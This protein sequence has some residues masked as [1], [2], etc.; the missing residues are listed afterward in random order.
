MTDYYDK[1]S[2]PSE[3]DDDEEAHNDIITLC[4]LVEEYKARIDD[5]KQ[6]LE[7]NSAAFD[8]LNEVMYK[9]YCIV[10]VVAYECI[11]VGQPVAQGA[12]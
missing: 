9:S 3:A 7:D 12:P 6:Q 4:H 5:F 11:I 8:K 1:Y 10:A 2:V